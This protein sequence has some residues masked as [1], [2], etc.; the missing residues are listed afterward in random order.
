MSSHSGAKAL[1]T[2][3]KNQVRGEGWWRLKAELGIN[4]EAEGPEDE[5]A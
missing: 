3:V 2:G 1:D 4:A 5:Q